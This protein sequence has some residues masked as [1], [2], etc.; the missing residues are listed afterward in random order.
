MDDENMIP[1]VEKFYELAVNPVIKEDF[2]KRL[3]YI[4][5]SKKTSEEASK[6]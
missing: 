5:E 6:N 2:R 3:D 1:F 4:R